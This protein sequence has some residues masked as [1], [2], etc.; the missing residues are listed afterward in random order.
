MPCALG[1]G[2]RLLE[3]PDGAVVVAGIGD[4]KSHVVQGGHAKHRVV[5][6][7]SECLLDV[8]E[9]VAT[10]G[11]DHGENVADPGEL[12]GIAF[13]FGGCHRLGRQVGRLLGVAGAMGQQGPIGVDGGRGRVTLDCQLEMLLRDLEAP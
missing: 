8:F 13:P 11:G 2:D 5:A 4:Q 9:R 6:G 7:Q 1:Y 10:I 12:T 3:V